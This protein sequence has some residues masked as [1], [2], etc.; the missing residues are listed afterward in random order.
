MRHL[1]GWPLLAFLVLSGLLDAV[2]TGVRVQTGIIERGGVLALL[3]NVPR[4]AFAF[5]VGILFFRSGAW[6]KAPRVPI[7]LIGV[8][9]A[10]FLIM[11]GENGPIYAVV[12]LLVILPATLLLGARASPGPAVSGVCAWLGDLSY[13]LYVLHFPV[14]RAV[15]YGIKTRVPDDRIQTAV[16]LLVSV[17]AAW[18][19][20]KL[21]DEPV[22]RWLRPPRKVLGLT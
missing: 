16:A 20:L 5:A 14:G 18:A 11:P 2:V 6:R 10:I 1:K 12:V 3:V 17:I 15:I 4:I 22:R 19:A 21:F 8:A 9:L 7:A 13:P